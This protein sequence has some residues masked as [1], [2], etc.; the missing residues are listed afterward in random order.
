MKKKKTIL[1]K[2]HC[3]F[4]FSKALLKINKADLLVSYD[5]NSLYQSAERDKDSTWPA[6]E[7]AYPFEKHNVD[8]VCESF[9]S[10]RWDELI[11]SAS[12]S[13]KNHYP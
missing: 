6:I 11:R 12:L 9:N 1:L 2:N 4:E 10:G 5:F 13:V 8:R 7:T 3:D